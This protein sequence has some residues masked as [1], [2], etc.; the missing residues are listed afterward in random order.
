MQLQ[1]PR[2]PFLTPACPEP[3]ERPWVTSSFPEPGRVTLWLGLLSEPPD[4][5]VLG[6]EKRRIW[7]G[8]LWGYPKEA[9]KETTQSFSL[10]SWNG[11]E[12]GQALW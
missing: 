8:D 5:T 7:A 6:S 12:A 10:S 9:R 3:V 11:Q 4:I 1:A 2:K